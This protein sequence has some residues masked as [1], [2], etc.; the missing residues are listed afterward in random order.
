MWCC[1]IKCPIC[2]RLLYFIGLPHFLTV[3]RLDVFFILFF[4]CHNLVYASFCYCEHVTDAGV[5]LLGTLP[6]LVSLD[7]SG[8]NIQD[9]GVAALG[10][11]PKFRDISLAECPNITDLGLQV[12]IWFKV[13]WCNS[14]VEVLGQWH[15]DR[16][17]SRVS[18][19]FSSCDKTG[20][21]MLEVC[22]PWDVDGEENCFQKLN[23]SKS[24]SSLICLF[25]V[26]LSVFVFQKMCQQCRQLE[27]FDVSHCKVRF[28]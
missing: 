24:W 18:L 11:N 17:I 1:A 7:L 23:F 6:S 25:I 28:L 14:R 21:K 22:G 5:E 4:R 3:V 15:N 12:S 8:C 26:C 2:L 19:S 13:K 9:Q 20:N 27:N 10:N 16:A